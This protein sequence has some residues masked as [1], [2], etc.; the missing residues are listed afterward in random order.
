VLGDL[1]A[2]DGKGALERITARWPAV[3][4]ALLLRIQALKLTL[5]Q[6]RAF[7]AVAAAREGGGADPLRAAEKDARAIERERMPW[8]DPY[9]PLI[10]A[11]VAAVRGDADA[12]R[13][14]LARAPELFDAADMKLWAAASRRRLG[15]MIG[16][17]EGATLVAEADAFMRG[18]GIASP[19][20]WTAMQA[21]GF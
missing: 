3:E 19:E 4:K 18:Q 17:D 7:A 13:A 9:V 1:Y 14:E 16:G 5:L 2:G 11:A 10:R 6:L 20:R 8:S 21:P 12:A 15:V